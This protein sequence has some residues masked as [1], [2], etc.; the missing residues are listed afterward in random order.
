MYPKII[1]NDI[2]RNKLITA[3]VMVFILVAA[4]LAALAGS[5]T[6]N[7]SGAINN[8][9][10]SA[11]SVHYMQMHTGSVDR[12]QLRSFADANDSVE[13][14]Q[15]LEFLNIEGADIVIGEDSLAGSIQD[16]GLSVQGE[17]FDFLLNLN[18]EVIHPEEGEIYVPIY[19][20]QEGD[21]ALGDRITI[22]GI[23]F[24]V[25]G[26]LRDSTMNAAMISSKRFLVSQADFEKVREF[27]QLEHLIEFRLAKNVSFPA[28]EVA[29]Q[30]AGLP[31]NGPPAIT[32]TQVKMINGITD[33]I[34][35]AVLVL[36]GI[37][38]IIVAFLCI[39]LTLLAKI[40][41]DYKEIGVLKAVGMRVSEIKKLYLAKYGAIA[42]A[43]C[44]LGFL[45][46]LPLQT[47]FMRNIRLYMGGSGRPLLGLLCG[48]LGAAVVCGGVMLFVNSILKRFRHIPA[49]QAVRF[50]TSPEQS[51]TA[52]SFRL[53]HNRL[54]SRNIFLGIKDVLSRK[55][56]YITMLMVL[57]ISSFI[58]IVPQNISSTI[59]AGNFITYMGM[60]IA[61][62]NI[63]VMRTQVEDV[64]GKSA[65]VA[66][67]L[68]E[69]KNVEKYAWFTSKMLERKADDGTMEKLRVGFGDYSVFPITYSKGRAPQADSELAL[70]A[71]NA[72]DLEKTVGDTIILIVDGADKLLT[73][74]GIYS[75]VTN[76]GRTAQAVF[77]ADSGDVL[78]VSLAV[79]FYDRQSVKAA[80]SQYREQFPF[81]KV[82]GID[83]S[84]GQ[85]LGS[86]RNAIKM[87]SA[88]A[89]LAAV[90]LT[91]MVTVLFMKMLVVKDRNSIAIM[92][93]IGFTGGDI[94][95]QYLTRS[96]TVL[97]L[98]VSI[99]TIL[100]NT[101]G[102][103][104][105]V[106]IV[107][108]FG[109]TT[110]HFSVNPWFVYVTS[111]LLITVCVVI[112]TLLGISGIQT[113]KISEHIKEA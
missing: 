58:M 91:L 62:V 18:G 53:S 50:G 111:P 36:I 22:H 95:R 16:N 75:D 32:Y 61:D 99:G 88:V 31:A 20:M 67:V 93:S 41:E 27:G 90:L 59:S 55:K 80:I 104:V 79:T 74:C 60:G 107:S 21:A 33:G 1:K 43:A 92:K 35:I 57:V 3:A 37:L 45:A 17:K 23:S 106:A 100:A 38:V 71:L 2:R 73:V 82:T 24:T 63:G 102:E 42:G 113:L 110:F 51:K 89:A 11:K 46:S 77:D 84:I 29:Y 9:L 85:M 66:D 83:E 40:E 112:A 103:F 39:R 78:S 30:G 5:L 48:L 25:T 47:P 49:A 7:L 4:M 19:Y 8:M 6:V 34:M 15:V 69:D 56:L 87:A 68:A 13:E 72:K 86:I 14:Y 28:F 108:S 64:L 101:L 65:A 109:A 96:L 12:E 105:G 44:I 81:A 54:F 76:G 98:G 97:A 26:F 94:C 52:R 70:S 10:I